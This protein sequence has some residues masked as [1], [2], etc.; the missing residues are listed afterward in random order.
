MHDLCRGNAVRP[1]SIIMCKAGERAFTSVEGSLIK[2]AGKKKTRDLPPRYSTAV[3]STQYGI[4]MDNGENGTV[5]TQ[6]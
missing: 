4:V 2:M 5:A 3:L 6:E 1:F